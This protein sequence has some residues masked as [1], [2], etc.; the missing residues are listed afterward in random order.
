MNDDLLDLPFDQFQRYRLV[1]DMIDDVR[2]GRRRF[3]ILD[4]GGRTGLLRRFLPRDHVQIVDLEVSGEKGLVL[5]D[6]AALPFASEAVDAVVA[7]D[8]LE[9]V[10][11]RRRRRF[12]TECHRVARRW[13]IIAGPYRTGPVQ[14]AERLLRE[15]LKDKLGIEHRYLEEHHTHGLPVRGEVERHLASLGGDLVSIGHASLTRWLPLMML[16]MYMDRDAPLRGIARHLHRFYNELIHPHDHEAPVYRHAVVAAL[17]GAVLPDPDA[18]LA[19]GAL[20]HKATEAPTHL[21]REL[22]R[23]DAQRDVVETEWQRLKEVID[24]LEADLGGHRASLAEIVDLRGEQDVLIEDLQVEFGAVQGELAVVSKEAARER[25]E[26]EEVIATLEEDLTGHRELVTDAAAELDR[27]REETEQERLVVEEDLAAHA[28]TIDEL[29]GLHAA[30][31]EGKEG[32]ESLLVQGAEEHARERETLESD[33]AEHGSVI[34]ELRR[35]LQAGEQER[36]TLHQELEERS[37]EQVEVVG[38]LEADLE[39]HRDL[40]RDARAEVEAREAELKVVRV[41]LERVV[42]DFERQRGEQQQVIEESM[43]DLEG[44]RSLAEELRSEL[45]KS[46]AGLERA[47]EMALRERAEQ[48]DVA[49]TLEADLAGHR[50]SLDDLRAELE[51]SVAA[52]RAVESAC[53]ERDRGLAVMSER[54]AV[55]E[56]L[57]ERLRETLNRRFEN[58]S[59]ALS[60][61]KRRY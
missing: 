58:L 53:A 28:K 46:A 44:H 12:L 4:V 40:A 19:R 15:F 61:R 5:G 33:L 11:K 56:E 20:E 59:R 47:H 51:K 13:V 38:A 16:S 29:R 21:L 30:E 26:Q 43:V 24:G 18:F 1:A 45:A 60:L 32:L 6:G 39:G 7:F 37:A 36:E 10:P 9:H 8:T 34:G 54:L 23:F 50:A 48:A 22:L 35:D 2:V 42:E 17:G 3:T 52:V 49:A 57:G 14:R 55:A 25:K 41:E 27:E 31:V